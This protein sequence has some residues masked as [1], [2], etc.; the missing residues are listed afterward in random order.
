MMRLLALDTATEACSVALW[1]DGAVA[2]AQRRLMVRGHAEALMP[3]VAAVMAE[4][5]LAYGDIDAFAVTRGP[6]TFTGLRIG[7][8]AARGLALAATRPLIG[9]TTLEVLAASVPVARRGHSLMAAIDARRG[10]IYGQVFATDLTPLGEPA[11]RSADALAAEPWVP[12]LQVVGTAAQR[13]ADLLGDGVT[14]L[15]GDG[16]PDAA[17][18]VALAATRSLPAV[19]VPVAPLY[20][21]P[22]DAR[23]PRTP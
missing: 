15:P 11:A 9:L 3:M 17:V 10:E 16:C 14:A 8:A 1:V 18:A 23:L 4:S 19:G 7:L 22:P 12:P 21:R 2:M 20:L 6:G 13:M 5:G